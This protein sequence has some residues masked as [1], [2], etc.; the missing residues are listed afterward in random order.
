MSKIA[1]MLVLVIVC[2]AGLAAFDSI[3]NLNA[4]EIVST[5][6]SSKLNEVIS[7]QEEILQKLDDM[8][9]QIQIVKIR[10]TR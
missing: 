4:E 8:A 3:N 9:K 5:D 6:L 10:A 1:I 2:I 7:N